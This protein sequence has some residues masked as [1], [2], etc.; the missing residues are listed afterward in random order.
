MSAEPTPETDPDPAE[1]AALQ[2]ERVRN[3][4]AQA[5]GCEARLERIKRDDLGAAEREYV[6]VHGGRETLEQRALLE[7]NN[8]RLRAI[9]RHLRI[10]EFVEPGGAEG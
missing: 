5:H 7:A 3:E 10:P 8:H 9:C 6:T 1:A 2:A 4:M